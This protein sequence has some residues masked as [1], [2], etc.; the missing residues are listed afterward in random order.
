M[1]LS[2]RCRLDRRPLCRPIM[3]E[4]GDRA[5]HHTLL[6]RSGEPFTLPKSLKAEKVRHFVYFYR[7]RAPGSQRARA[8]FLVE[9]APAADVGD[10]LAAQAGRFCKGA[11]RGSLPLGD[12]DDPVS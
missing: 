6:D 10:G 5:P 11:E 7:A 9:E 4:T 8:R 1:C 3:L 12:A 2:R